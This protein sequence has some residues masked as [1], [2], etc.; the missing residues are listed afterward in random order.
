ME[1]EIIDLAAAMYA[2]ADTYSVTACDLGLF[3]K[4]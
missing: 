1:Q 4:D 2:A 3:A